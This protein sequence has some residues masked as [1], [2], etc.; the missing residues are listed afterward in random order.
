MKTIK[1]LFALILA[2]IISLSCLPVYTLAS[3]GGDKVAAYAKACANGTYGNFVY[4]S[5]YVCST[6]IDYVYKQCGF[7]IT[8][9]TQKL[10]NNSGYS[11]DWE[12]IT[13]AELQPGDVLCWKGK[14][15][16]LFVG[17]NKCVNMSNYTSGNDARLEKVYG[18]TNVYMEGSMGTPTCFRYKNF[19]SSGSTTP[20]TPTSVITWKKIYVENIT[21]TSAVVKTDV[22]CTASQISKIGLQMGKASNSMTS[23]ASWKVN[24]ILDYC[25]VK[26][27]GSE[28]AK[29]SPDTTYYYRFYII[30]NDGTYVYSPTNSF[31]TKT[32]KPTT[33]NNHRLNKNSFTQGES[34]IFSW[35]AVTYANNYRVVI[36]NGNQVV[37]DSDVGNKTSYTYIPTSVGTYY[38]MVYAKNSAGTSSAT[39]K[40]SASVS[41]AVTTPVV[42]D[43]PEN[44]SDTCSCK[45]HKGGI[46]S[47]FFKI[48]IFVQRLLGINSVCICGAEHN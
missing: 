19:G 15:V 1:K 36:Y 43:V 34:I 12:K 31:K 47:F 40:I 48:I 7:K 41:A 9:S 33:P 17:D 29:L 11:T 14:H 35:N 20:T 22:T 28:A 42:P 8:N 5:P 46:I 23:V 16:A 27:D 25:Y 6:F 2:L 30:K 13:K 18:S 4:G 10:I 3:A 21:E 37:F 32:P 24:S 26:C 39:S 38:F 44:P 45:C